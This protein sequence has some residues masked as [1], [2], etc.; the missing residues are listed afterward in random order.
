MSFKPRDG[1]STS[2]QQ[3]LL[4]TYRSQ[5]VAFGVKLQ[6]DDFFDDFCNNG[7]KVVHL[8]R[9]NPMI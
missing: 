4:I 8:P 2:F 7:K 6:F 9:N 5:E 1:T 3:K